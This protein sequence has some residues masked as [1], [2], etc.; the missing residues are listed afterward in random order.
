MCGHMVMNCVDWLVYAAGEMTPL[1][2]LIIPASLRR[3]TASLARTGRGG[4]VKT[5]VLRGASNSQR[6]EV[7]GALARALGRALAL[8]KPPALAEETT[9]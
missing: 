1:D 3:S 9:A 5:V 6:Q 7:M 4:Q 2:E 8:L